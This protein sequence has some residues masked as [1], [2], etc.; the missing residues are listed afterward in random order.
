MGLIKNTMYKLLH[1]HSNV[2]FIDHS[3]RYINNNISNEI[4]FILD[5]DT[6]SNVSSKLNEYGI[7]FLLYDNSKKGLKEIIVRSEQFDGVIFHSLGEP[8]VKILCGINSK[9]KTF[10][11]FFGYE[12]YNLEMK[13][14]LTEKTLKIYQ[15]PVENFSI[16]SLLKRKL[17]I[18]LNL[19]Y[20]VNLDNQKKIYKKF[21]AILIVNKYEY[22]ELNHFFYLPKLI[23]RQL[24]DQIGDINKCKVIANK[25]NQVI[26]G[27]HGGE[28]N[29]HIDILDIIKDFDNKSGIEFKMFFSY[30]NQREYAYKIKK[31]A[32]G[33]NRVTLIENFLSM[34]EFEMVYESSAAVV[35]NSYRQNALGNIFM[36]IEVGCKVYLNKKGS[37]YK[38]LISEGF[39]IS[40]VSD[41]EN[42]LKTGNIRL[43]TDEQ[44]KNIDRFIHVLKSYTVDDF[45]NNIISVLNTN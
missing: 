11:K 5:N 8:Q 19:D 39:N 17:Q 26:V 34:K 3:R 21:D 42:D 13:N 9:V 30:G 14:F 24:I 6:S 18:L 41:L 31:I 36:A 29:N 15:P 43:T 12:L 22:E 38:W 32:M 25:A 2:I 44:Q 45:L 28:I 35:I 40:E 23:E 4:A 27:N 1:I 10:L 33:M 37:T 20:Y 7:P 16:F